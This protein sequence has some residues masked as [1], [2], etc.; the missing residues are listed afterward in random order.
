M[1][2]MLLGIISKEIN[3]K[4]EKTIVFVRRQWSILLA[5]LFNILDLRRMPIKAKNC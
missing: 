5:F 4:K 1:I 2:Q 3:T